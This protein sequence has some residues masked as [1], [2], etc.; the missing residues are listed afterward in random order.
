V[1]YLIISITLL[2]IACS[3]NKSNIVDLKKT[4]MT[5]G[6]IYDIKRN[7]FIKKTTSLFNYLITDYGYQSPKHKTYHQDNGTVINDELVYL[8]LDSSRQLI[9]SNSYHPVDYGFEINLKSNINSKTEM[10]HYVLKEDQDMEQSYLDEVSILLK[11]KFQK[12]L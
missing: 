11:T 6:E 3:P 12:K 7:N 4:T 9:I 5:P 1:K 10:L 2:S 8:K